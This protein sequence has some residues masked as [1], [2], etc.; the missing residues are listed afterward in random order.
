MKAQSV[1][2]PTTA[3]SIKEGLN[4]RGKLRS[5]ANLAPALKPQSGKGLRLRNRVESDCGNS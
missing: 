4:E 3:N 2:D 5:K 1:L